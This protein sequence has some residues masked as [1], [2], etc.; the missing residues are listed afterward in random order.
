MRLQEREE[1]SDLS[2]KTAFVSS[3][4]FRK[5][6]LSKPSISNEND[7]KKK[8]FLLKCYRCGL[9][10]HLKRDYMKEAKQKS[11]ASST[12]GSAFVSDAFP[13]TT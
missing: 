10:V 4:N 5:Q 12:Q 2:S 1:N 6:S 3:K 13:L 9:G 7:N 11:E 8:R